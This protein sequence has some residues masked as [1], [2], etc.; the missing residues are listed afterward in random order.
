MAI[1][2]TNVEK[3]SDCYNSFHFTSDED[4]SDID[5]IIQKFDE[6]FTGEINETWMS[7]YYEIFQNHVIFV[8]A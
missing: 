4:H 8:N 3:L 2:E 7:K 6:Q 1:I 5:T